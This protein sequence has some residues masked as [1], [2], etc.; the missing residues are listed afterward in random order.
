MTLDDGD[1][2]IAA[3]LAVDS[4]GRILVAGSSRDLLNDT[5]HM[6]L[7]TE[8]EHRHQ[9]GQEECTEEWEPGGASRQGVHG[10]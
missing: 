4:T 10:A 3:A 8:Q 1:D 2:E 6:L 9:D 7:V 5:G